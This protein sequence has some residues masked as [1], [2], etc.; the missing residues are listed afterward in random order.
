M[1][2]KRKCTHST[3]FSNKK[4]IF[5]HTHS[6][7]LTLANIKIYIKKANISS[8]N[9]YNNKYNYNYNKSN[10]KVPVKYKLI[11]NI[12]FVIY[13]LYEHKKKNILLYYFFGF[14]LFSVT[15]FNISGEQKIKYAF[16]ALKSVSIDV[17][18]RLTL[19][20]Q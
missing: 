10:K 15:W 13:K 7:V 8:I 12:T 14:P 6:N 4:Q 2:W 3:K 17:S 16:K 1:I 9:A 11:H 5:T 18:F 19:K 20:A